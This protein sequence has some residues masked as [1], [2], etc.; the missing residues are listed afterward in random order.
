MS[1]TYPLLGAKR[2]TRGGGRKID[3]VSSINPA[4][5]FIGSFPAPT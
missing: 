3:M 5:V 4:L 2:F 1:S